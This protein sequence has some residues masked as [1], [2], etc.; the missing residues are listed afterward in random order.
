MGLTWW[1]ETTNSP[2]L[3]SDPHIFHEDMGEEE[4]R[5][6]EEEEQDRI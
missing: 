2:K 3:S 6:R 4:K 1:K 5:R